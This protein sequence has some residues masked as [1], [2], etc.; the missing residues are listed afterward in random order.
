MTRREEDG[1]EEKE[2]KKDSKELKVSSCFHS[3]LLKF[4]I[5]Y[6]LQ[7]DEEVVPVD[8]ASISAISLASLHSLF[9]V[10]SFFN[11]IWL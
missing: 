1:G 3:Y 11:P 7:N 6:G 8:S 2:E 5:L 9:T 4:P 10:V